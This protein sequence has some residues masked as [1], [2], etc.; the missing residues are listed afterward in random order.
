VRGGGANKTQ[1]VYYSGLNFHAVVPYLK[2]II[3]NDLAVKAEGA[4]F[5]YKT[6]PKGEDGALS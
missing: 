2:L 3:R 4:V 1:I 6:T 5:K